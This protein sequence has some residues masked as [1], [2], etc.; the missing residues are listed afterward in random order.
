MSLYRCGRQSNESL[1]MPVFYA[2]EHVI[3]TLYGKRRFAGSIKLRALRLGDHLQLFR[4]ACS[5]DKGLYKYKK[6][7]EEDYK[8]EIRLL[9]RSIGQRNALLL[10]L[11]TEG[12]PTLARSVGDL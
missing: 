6:K 10:I 9:K 4:W 1:G 5:N 12:D 11:K 8:R 7:A 2:L 3:V